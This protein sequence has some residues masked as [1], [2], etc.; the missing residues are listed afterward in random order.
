MAPVPNPKVVYDGFDRFRFED[1]D[2]IEVDAVE[3]KDG[4][5]LVHTLSVSLD[6]FMIT[7]M[8]GTN[9]TFPTYEEGK[10]RLSLIGKVLHTKSRKFKEGDLLFAFGDFRRYSILDEND[11]LRGPITTT[12][13]PVPIA[14]SVWLGA[15]GM[16]GISAYAGWEEFARPKDGE[17]CFVTSGAGQVGSMAIQ[18]AKQAGLKVIASAGSDEKLE[19]MKRCGADSVFNYK[20]TSVDDALKAFGKIDVYWDNVGGET[21]DIT[22]NHMNRLGRMILCGAAS[23][24]GAKEHH[25]SKNFHQIHDLCLSVNGFLVSDLAAK[26]QSKFYEAMV[27]LV[28]AGRIIYEETVYEGLENTTKAFKDLLAGN[29]IGKVTVKP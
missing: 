24:Y 4:Q 23:E 25:A 20:T 2:V 9:S 11:P 29:A 5:T 21:T 22:L 6:P 7:R 13:P 18:L 3:L 14:P 10:H 28:L 19:F 17:T 8:S 27:P 15:L 12:V 26:Y 1:S 16:P